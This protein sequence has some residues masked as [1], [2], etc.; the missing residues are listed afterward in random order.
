MDSRVLFSV[1]FLFVLKYYSIIKDFHLHVVSEENNLAS[2]PGHS[3]L[4]F[5]IACSMQNEGWRPGREKESCAWRQVDVKVGAVPDKESWG[6]FFKISPRP[7]DCN[8]RKTVSIH[9][10]ILYI[11]GWVCKL[12]R[13]GI[14]PLMSSSSMSPFLP[15]IFAC[16][17]RS[18]TGGLAR[19]LETKFPKLILIF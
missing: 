13:S 14:T 15:G 10:I 5:L 12:Q 9:L 8:V 4:Q 1:N 11:W 7:W 16:C 17:K 19:R 2:L 18:K 3:R 6:S